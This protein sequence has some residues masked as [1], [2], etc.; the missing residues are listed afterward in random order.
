M[1]VSPLLSL[2]LTSGGLSGW[3]AYGVGSSA[4]PSNSSSNSVPQ[5]GGSRHSDKTPHNK[6]EGKTDG[7]SQNAQSLISA[8]LSPKSA[9]PTFSKA[10]SPVYT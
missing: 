3:L 5:A 7:R 6:A 9:E 4:A 2:L 8:N 1:R 10:F